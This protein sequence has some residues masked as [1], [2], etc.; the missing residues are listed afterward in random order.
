MLRRCDLCSEWCHVR[1]EDCSAAV[2]IDSEAMEVDSLALKSSGEDE[3][4][5]CATCIEMMGVESV[6][7]VRAAI[8]AAHDPV[9]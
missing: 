2:P 3:R 1:V 4:F 9:S 5:T 8:E 7:G 6:G